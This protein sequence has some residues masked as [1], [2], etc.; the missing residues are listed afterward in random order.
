MAAFKTQKL[1]HKIRTKDLERKTDDVGYAERSTAKLCPQILGC[2]RR[3]Q[4]FIELVINKRCCHLHHYDNG[5]NKCQVFRISNRR[6]T[7][8]KIIDLRLLNTCFLNLALF[9]QVIK[10]NAQD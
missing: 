8:H 7:L 5:Q 2:N 6:N 9:D 3:L 4:N 1:N 10:S